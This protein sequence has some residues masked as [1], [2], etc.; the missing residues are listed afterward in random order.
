M[1]VALVYSVR[2]FKILCPSFLSLSVIW[3][4]VFLFLIKLHK[5]GPEVEMPISLI[6]FRPLVP[7]VPKVRTVI[8]TNW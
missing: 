1:K 3:D 8:G 5:H 7:Q 2:N 4:F 6:N